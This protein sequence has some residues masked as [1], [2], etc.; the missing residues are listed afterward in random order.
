VPCILLT[1]H[2]A[3]IMTVTVK[4]MYC[5]RILLLLL[6]S[7]VGL[8][9]RRLSPSQW[10]LTRGITVQE[11]VMPRGDVT[12]DVLYITDCDLDGLIW[13][14]RKGFWSLQFQKGLSHKHVSPHRCAVKCIN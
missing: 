8:L 14:L 5:V 6:L 10:S 4:K 2:V 12:R 9:G 11:P 3:E 1:P 7:S 13:Y